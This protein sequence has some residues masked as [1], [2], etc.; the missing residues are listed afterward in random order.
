MKLNDILCGDNLQILKSMKENTFDCGI[1]SPPYNKHITKNSGKLVSAINYV[2]YKDDLDEK[3]YQDNQIILLNEIYRIM[4]PGGSFFYNHKIRWQNG[5]M[6]HPIEWLNKTNWNIRQEIIWNRKIAANIRGFRFWQI[7]ERIYWLYKPIGNNLIGKEL[8]SKHA[9]LSSVW[10]LPPER[11]SFHPAPFPLSIP[12][13]CLYSILNENKN[14]LVLDPFM[15]SGTTGVACKFLGYNYMGIEISNDYIQK[16]NKRIENY[17][18]EKNDFYDEFNKHII[19][20]N[21]KT[22]KNNQNYLF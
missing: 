13:R 19:K 11:N 12:V 9:L 17:R 20:N 4:K 16:A 1:T 6:I 15:G 10:E 8:Q 2:D 7:D 14:A 22:Q 21:K 18:L 3:D 5:I